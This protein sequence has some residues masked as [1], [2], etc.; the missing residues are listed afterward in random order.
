MDFI[1][2]LLFGLCLDAAM[3]MLLRVPHPGRLLPISL[4][5]GYVCGIVSAALR[6][7]PVLVAVYALG[8]ILCAVLLWKGGRRA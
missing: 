3:L 7:L 8:A 5:L 6:A 2:E 4:A 1:M